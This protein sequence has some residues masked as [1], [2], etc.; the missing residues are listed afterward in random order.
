MLLHN[1]PLELSY[2]RRRGYIVMVRVSR[3]ARSK[4]FGGQADR[5]EGQNEV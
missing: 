1:L 2:C 3:R 5:E 4:A